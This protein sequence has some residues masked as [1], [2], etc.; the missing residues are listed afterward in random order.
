VKITSTVFVRVS[1]FVIQAEIINQCFP[2]KES[3]YY[4]FIN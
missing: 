1:V 4:D 2:F 3:Q